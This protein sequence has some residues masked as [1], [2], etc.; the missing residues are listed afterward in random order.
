MIRG[1]TLADVG[2]SNVSMSA[3][4]FYAVVDAV[5]RHGGVRHGP[6]ARGTAVTGA[7]ADLLTLSRPCE[8]KEHAHPRHSHR[9]TLP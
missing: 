2:R 3:S 6:E 7:P 5:P 8:Q 1:A 4:A 9:L